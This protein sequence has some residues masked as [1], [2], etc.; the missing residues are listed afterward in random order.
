MS[1]RNK[2][3][4]KFFAILIVLISV[5]LELD[6]LNLHFLEPYK[7]WMTVLGFGMLLIVSR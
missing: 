1:K 7:Y 4:I 6:V 3:L 5:L 2:F